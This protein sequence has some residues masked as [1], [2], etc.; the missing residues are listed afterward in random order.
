MLL[1]QKNNQNHKIKN[2]NNRKSN[3][4]RYSSGRRPRTKVNYRELDN[5]SDFEYEESAIVNKVSS[6]GRVI[7]SKSNRSRD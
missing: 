6:K 7:K 4:D 1:I 3:S 2:R 5:G